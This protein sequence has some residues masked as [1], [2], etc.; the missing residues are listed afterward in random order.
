M[1]ITNSVDIKAPPEVVFSW[2]SQPERS[3]QWMESVTNTEIIH[4]AP[5]MVGTTFVEEITE[6]GRSTQLRGVIT[7]YELNKKIAMRLDGDYNTVDVE[8]RL[9]QVG[10]ITRVIEDGNVEFKSF[11][12]IIM[13]FVGPLF[14]KKAS[15]GL[16]QEFAKLKE[17][18]E[19][20]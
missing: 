16:Q 15:A 20:Q 11:L 9:E 5:D 18:C 6:K 17:L 7:G 19:K 10:D 13:F 14:Q 8:Y 12:K 2:L 3:M 1:R 4:K